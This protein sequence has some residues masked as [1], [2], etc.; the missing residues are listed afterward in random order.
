MI[1]LGF[2]AALNASVRRVFYEVTTVFSD[3]N[4]TSNSL[5]LS[6][7]IGIIIPFIA[8]LFPLRKAL[9]SNL[10]ASLD[11]HHRHVGELQIIMKKFQD[12]D[13]SLP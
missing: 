1:G 11:V 10:R 13:M 9:E 3:Y 12:V 6:I 5:Q 7:S 4:L 8:N 2:G